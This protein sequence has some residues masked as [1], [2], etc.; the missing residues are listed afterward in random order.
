V[1][2]KTGN[3]GW[4]VEWLGKLVGPEKAVRQAC[5]GWV[6]IYAWSV[7]LGSKNF[8]HPYL[9]KTTGYHL[10]LPV[11]KFPRAASPLFDRDGF[12][13]TTHPC[14]ARFVSRTFAVE[15][16]GKG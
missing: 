13:L 10:P 9:P 4:L 12:L 7:S 8:C 6:A 11:Q 2:N 14:L 1:D 15:G 16:L 3:G 5:R